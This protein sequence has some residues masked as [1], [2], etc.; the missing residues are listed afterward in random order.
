MKNIQQNKRVKR[1][2]DNGENHE[3][4]K[5]WCYTCAK[6]RHKPGVVTSYNKDKCKFNKCYNNGKGYRNCKDFNPKT[7][8]TALTKLTDQLNGLDAKVSGKGKKGKRIVTADPGSY[9][10]LLVGSIV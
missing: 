6:A 1:D 9:F 5:K 4:G 10:L 8:M 7:I 3:N 2:N